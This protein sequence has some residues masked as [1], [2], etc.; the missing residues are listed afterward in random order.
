MNEQL[1][2]QLYTKY[3]KI[4]AQ[5][6]LSAQE[7]CMVWGLECGDGWFHLIDSLCR[8]IQKHCNVSDFQVEATQVKEKFGSLR[9]YINSGDDY[10]YALI[11]KAEQISYKTCEKCG[12]TKNTQHTRGWIVTLCSKCMK[13][14]KKERSLR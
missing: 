9:F 12:S 4:F 13:L 8:D 3:P 2:Q 6:N 14:Y 5:R 7:T 11:E 10:I 1:T